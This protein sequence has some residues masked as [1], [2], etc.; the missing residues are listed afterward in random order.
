MFIT[1]LINCENMIS[2]SALGKKKYYKEC[3]EKKKRPK[4]SNNTKER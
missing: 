2:K 1:I 3:Q 4:K